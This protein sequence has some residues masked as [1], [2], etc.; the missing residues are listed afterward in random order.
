[1]G[2]LEARAGGGECLCFKPL[3]SALTPGWLPLLLLGSL[4]QVLEL[5]SERQDVV[6]W[7]RHLIPGDLKAP[8]PPPIC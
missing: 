5:Q 3:I 6:F 1:M 4:S 7:E 2:I 8:S